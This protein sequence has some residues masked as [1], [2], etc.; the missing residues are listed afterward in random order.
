MKVKFKKFWPSAITPRYQTEGAAGLD[1]NAD[2][3]HSVAPGGV[4]VIR[5]GVGLALPPGYEGQVR[6]RSSLSLRGIICATGTIDSDYRGEIAVILINL[7]AVMF[8]VLPCDRIAQLVITPVVRA[9]LELADELPATERGE[10]GFGST[11]VR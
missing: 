4:V 5:T 6:G 1:L 3:W 9:E 8:E 11:G 7:G 10:G 2:R